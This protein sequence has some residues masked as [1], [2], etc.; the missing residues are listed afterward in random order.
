MLIPDYSNIFRYSIL[1][2]IC[3]NNLFCS[4][5][6]QSSRKLNLEEFQQIKVNTLQKICCIIIMR[7]VTGRNLNIKKIYKI[8]WKELEAQ[9]ILK[10]IAFEISQQ[11]KDELALV[12][13]I[14]SELG[15]VED[16]VSIWNYMTNSISKVTINED[17]QWKGESISVLI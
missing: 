1:T 15:V 13:L 4:N 14:R 10:N 5:G 16:D 9:Q 17:P 8:N 11:S 12:E 6:E 3:S 2:L 7:K